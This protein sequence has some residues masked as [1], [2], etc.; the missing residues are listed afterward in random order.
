M[1]YPN[2][3]HPPRSRDLPKCNTSVFIPSKEE[4]EEEEVEGM[5]TQEG[6]HEEGSVLVQGLTTRHLYQHT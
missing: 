3:N 1:S 2:S 4:E 6:I 5:M